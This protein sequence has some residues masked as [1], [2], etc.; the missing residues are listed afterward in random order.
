MRVAITPSSFAEVEKLPLEILKSAGC[1]VILNPYG[2]RLTEAEVLDLLTRNNVEG[3]VAGLEPLTRAVLESASP[4]LKAIARVGIGITNVDLEACSDLGIRFSFTPDGPTEAVAEITCAALLCLIRD[5]VAMNGDMHSGVWRKRLGRGVRGLRVLV[6]GF[7]RIGRVV[8]QTLK[9]L[10]CEIMVCDPLTT[11]QMM[12]D[13]DRVELIDG[14]RA[15]DV[16]TLHASG[17]DQIIGKAELNAARKGVII[18]N[19]ARG[20]LIHEPSLI[21]ALDSGKV[22]KVWLDV[23][24]EE[25]YTGQLTQYEQVLMT[26]HASTYTLECRKEMESQAAKNLVRDLNLIV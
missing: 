24:R 13:M 20:E 10:G 16:V 15:A 4:A 9:K 2:R 14:L 23:F 17:Q 25:P 12:G 7:G 21:S 6:V 18:L 26:P 1:E 22:S 3:L 11:A 8:A 5:I 19:A